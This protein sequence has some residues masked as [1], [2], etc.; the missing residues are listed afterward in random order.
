MIKDS[1]SMDYIKFISWL[2]HLIDGPNQGRSIHKLGA[3]ELDRGTQRALVSAQRRW[4]VIV[5]IPP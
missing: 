5:R 1:G 3:E 4:E 2:S